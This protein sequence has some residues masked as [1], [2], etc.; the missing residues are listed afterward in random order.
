MATTKWALDPTHSELTFKIRHLMISNVRGEFQ[1]VAGS[2]TYDAARP[3]ALTIRAEIDV[4]S[5]NTRDAKRDAHLRSADFFDVENIGVSV[6]PRVSSHSKA[7][8][9]KASRKP[10]C[11][12]SSGRFA[13]RK[14]CTLVRAPS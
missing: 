9:I 14:C 3:E 12:I 6:H 7:P 11:V 10:S 5:I 8:R 1:K 2:A 4:G 13:L